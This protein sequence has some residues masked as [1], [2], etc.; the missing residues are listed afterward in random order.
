MNPQT[1]IDEAADDPLRPSESADEGLD[2]L[3]LALELEAGR[4]RSSRRG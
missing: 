3:Q 2:V 4:D 1:A